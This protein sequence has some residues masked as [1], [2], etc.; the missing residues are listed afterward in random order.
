MLLHLA[1]PHLGALRAPSDGVAYPSLQAPADHAVLLRFLLD[2]L[3]YNNG[4]E[5]RRR[6]RWP[7][8]SLTTPD[9]PLT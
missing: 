6:A 3:L 4:C 2:V 5:A 7:I 9:R 1:L 8:T